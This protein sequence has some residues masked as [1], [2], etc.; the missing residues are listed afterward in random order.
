MRRCVWPAS[1]FNELERNSVLPVQ[2]G[3]RPDGIRVALTAVALAMGFMLS[4]ANARSDEPA[5]PFHESELIFPPQH[6]HTHGSCIVECANGDLIACWY[7][8]SGERRADDVGV[9]GARKR[10]GE[11]RWSEV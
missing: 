10:R 5:G 2:S 1:D 6:L 7:R 11:K 4:A 8:G 9:Y 3:S